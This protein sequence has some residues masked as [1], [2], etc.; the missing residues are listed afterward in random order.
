MQSEKGTAEASEILGILFLI[1][2]YK[3]N[4]ILKV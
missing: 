1:L 3:Y 4:K 2:I